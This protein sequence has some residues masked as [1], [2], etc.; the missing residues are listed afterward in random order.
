MPIDTRYAGAAADKAYMEKTSARLHRLAYD[1]E[2][3][4]VSF[5]EISRGLRNRS[6]GLSLL[7]FALPSCFPMP[8]GVPTLCGI[9]I[10]MVAVQLITGRESLWLP[11]R[12]ARR[13]FT[14]ADLRRL[15]DRTSGYVEWLERFCRPRLAVVTERLGRRLLGIV[16]AIMAVM[17]I[18]PIPILGNVLPAIATAVIGLGLVERDGAIVV[19]GLGWALAAAAFTWAAAWLALQGIASFV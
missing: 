6:L 19:T 11:P 9:A 3:E 13:T 18:L 17:L 2:G 14:R 16:A 5:G 12:L 10:L 15:I 8:P 7:V 1:R 4:R